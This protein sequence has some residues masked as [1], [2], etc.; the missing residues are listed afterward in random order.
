VLPSRR[1]TLRRA[2][3]C[4]MVQ[5]CNSDPSPCDLEAVLDPG[6]FKALAEPNRIVL[7][8]HLAGHR[9]PSTVSEAAGCCTIDLS[10]VSRHLAT[11]RDA[12]VVNAERRGRQVYYS[13]SHGEV[14]R[15]LRVVADALEA[16]CS[17]E[18]RRDVREIQG[19]SS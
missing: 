2:S 5:A 10:V 17:D 4:T 1:M 3:L 6:F 8:A 18:A 19:R 16:C 14:A 7:I 9:E 15:R 13:V 11:L 12:G